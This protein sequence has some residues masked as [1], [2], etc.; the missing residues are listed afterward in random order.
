[1]STARCSS[2]P[3]WWSSSMVALHRSRRLCAS[4]HHSGCRCFLSGPAS[5]A[6]NHAGPCHASP[7]HAP[8]RLALFQLH[9]FDEEAAVFRGVVA[10]AEQAGRLVEPDDFVAIEHG[11][12]IGAVDKDVPFGKQRASTDRQ[13]T[14]HP[15]DGTVPETLVRPETVRSLRTVVL[16]ECGAFRP[17]PSA[18]NVS[19]RLAASTSCRGP[20]S[21]S[22]AGRGDR[23]YGYRY[24]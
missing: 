8:A 6:D 18:P 24:A 23:P 2:L 4:Q 3:R 1:L 12:Q 5:L 22:P 11:G 17:E 15:D 19:V 9:F 16:Q 20:F 13:G 7:G 21:L 10:E 14:V